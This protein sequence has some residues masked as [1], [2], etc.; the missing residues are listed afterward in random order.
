QIG[1]IKQ[2]V[3]IDRQHAS[4]GQHINNQNENNHYLAAYVVTNIDGGEIES[5]AFIDTIRQQLTTML[6]D[7]M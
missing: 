5:K 2:A 1:G 4:H 7:Y 6:P 3:V